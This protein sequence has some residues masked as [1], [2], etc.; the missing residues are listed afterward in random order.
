M[1]LARFGTPGSEKPAR[2]DTEG[3]LRDL[4]EHLPDITA[5][6]LS[7]KQLEKI[8]A[9]DIDQLP[10]VDDHARIGPPVAEVGRIICMGLNYKD[11]AAET[12][13]DLPAEPL[14]FM[15][16]C[17]PSGPNDNIYLPCGSKKADWEVELA[18]VIGKRG[19]YITEEESLSYVAGYCVFRDTFWKSCL[20]ARP[21]Q[22]F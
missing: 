16:G 2:I 11:H 19:L 18:V 21:R 10:L 17:H 3:R 13:L 9:I 1:K 6:S 14:V 4:S 15:K 7:D 20:P 5:E 12:N 8:A 22:I